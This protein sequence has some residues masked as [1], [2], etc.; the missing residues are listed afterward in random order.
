MKQYQIVWREQQWHLMIEGQE[1]GLLQSDDRSYLVQIAC[2]VAAERGSAVDVFDAR[3][4]L[5]TRLSFR[6]GT[7]AIDGSYPGD[8]A[9]SA[10]PGAFQRPSLL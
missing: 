7:L 10:D 3:N 9:I 8:P 6:D 4:K 5:E 2:K 1:C